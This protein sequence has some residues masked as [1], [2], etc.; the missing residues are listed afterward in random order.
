MATFSTAG[1]GARAGLAMKTERGFIK[2]IS[3]AATIGSTYRMFIPTFVGVDE[4]G[5]EYDDLLIGFGAGRKLDFNVFGS[6]FMTYPRSWYEDENNIPRCKVGCDQFNR[7]SK[8]ILEAQCNSEKEAAKKAADEIALA[9]GGQRDEIALIRKIDRIDEK[10]HGRDAEDGTQRIYAKV[11]PMVGRLDYFMVAEVLLVPMD[12]TTNTPNWSKAVPAYKTL[13]NQFLEKIFTIMKTP[14]FYNREDGFLEIAFKYGS[15][16]QEKN[17]AGLAATYNGV[18]RDMSL[19]NAFAD[20]WAKFGAAKIAKIAGGERDI[21]KA[22][23]LILKRTGFKPGA[24]TGADCKSK[25]LKWVSKNT[26]ILLN[27]DI[28][29]DNTKNAAK[30]II[31]LGIVDNVSTVKSKLQEIVD[32]QK[33]DEEEETPTTVDE[34]VN[35]MVAEE[36]APEPE[37]TTPSMVAQ[38]S[39]IINSGA[40]IGARVGQGVSLN[41][42]MIDD[43]DLGDLLG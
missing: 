29:D 10:Y 25:L 20:Q 11:S 2:Q 9:N 34:S 35:A 19:K 13:G 5:E 4:I 38:A 37:S 14:G 16:G 24:F 30:D 42:N 40:P 22:N 43:D 23:D 26:V 28:A 1:K 3:K 17:E 15:E 33:E 7:I 32:S 31:G 39:D 36:P 27:I 41:E 12:T 8:V 21:D 18:P 6:T